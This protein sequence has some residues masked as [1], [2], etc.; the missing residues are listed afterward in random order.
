[1]TTDRLPDD[2]ECLCLWGRYRSNNLKLW[3]N[4]SPDWH[5]LA[6][7]EARQMM[8]DY[9]AGRARNVDKLLACVEGKAERLLRSSRHVQVRVL[10][11][12]MLVDVAHARDFIAAS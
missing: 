4:I 5:R 6:L 9:H 2:A 11:T 12:G 8:N 1:M 3:H 7:T 10:A